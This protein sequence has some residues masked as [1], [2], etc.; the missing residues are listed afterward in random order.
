MTVDNDYAELFELAPPPTPE[1]AVDVLRRYLGQDLT[2]RHSQLT[3]AFLTPYLRTLLA[4]YSELWREKHD[5]SGNHPKARQCSACGA[6]WT[7]A[8]VY[9][10]AQ[11]P[12]YGANIGLGLR[13]L[14]KD[15]AACQQRQRE[16]AEGG[17][18]D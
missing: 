15:T 1:Q 10:P 12:E 13:W 9:V 2:G 7:L 11:Q 18:G 16:T 6:E 3:Q 17:N 14:C 5:G 4:A 8:D